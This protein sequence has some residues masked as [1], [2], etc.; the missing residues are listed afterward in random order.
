MNSV[1]HSARFVEKTDTTHVDTFKARQLGCLGYMQD[2]R[3][4]LYQK[5]LRQHTFSS[6]LVSP[7]TLP[8]VAVVY[9]Y[10]GLGLR[11]S[12]RWLG[13]KRGWS[14]PVSAR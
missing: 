6:D 12:C 2:G 10:V 5:P 14:W 9:A 8:A 1:I 4:R 13:G 11:T 7:L 3:V